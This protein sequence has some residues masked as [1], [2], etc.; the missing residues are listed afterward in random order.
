M[1]P[2]DDYQQANFSRLGPAGEQFLKETPW[3]NPNHSAHKMYQQ[4]SGLP[5]IR[6]EPPLGG[7]RVT[8]HNLASSTADMKSALDGAAAAQ[9]PAAAP[10]RLSE[11]PELARSILNPA[12]HQMK[13]V[14][15][16]P[17]L[18]RGSKAAAA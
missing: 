12:A 16:I 14:R 4:T 17:N 13:R 3:A 8:L 5:E 7:N 1:H 2:R 10:A 9:K 18:G 6:P 11:S 15:S